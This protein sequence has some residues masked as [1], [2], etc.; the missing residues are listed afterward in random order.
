MTRKAKGHSPNKADEAEVQSW[1]QTLEPLQPFSPSPQFRD[2]VFA[3]MQQQLNSGRWGTRLAVWFS[4]MK[5]R[6]VM[7]GALAAGVILALSVAV[8]RGVTELEPH[9]LDHAPAVLGYQGNPNTLWPTYQFQQHLV[10]AAAPG[11]LVLDDTLFEMSHQAYGFASLPARTQFF[12]LGANYAQALVLL[13]NHDQ[14]RAV[15][16][17][18]DLV[19]GLRQV[20]AP[21]ELSSYLHT[22]QAMFQNQ[23]IDS[24]T[25]AQ[26]LASVES[27][28]TATYQA[29]TDGADGLTYFRFGAWVVNL[30]LAASV[31]AEAVLRQ[32]TRIEALQHTLAQHEAAPSVLETLAQL[33][34][35]VKRPTLT[36]S[37]MRQVQILAQSLK[38]MMRD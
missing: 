23:Q 16:H 1:F 33:H 3:D 29:A 9:R 35:L 36:D 22:L 2:K 12:R 19:E 31:N 7:S 10:R 4:S 26:V 37:E 38:R 20:Q 25:L 30:S 21:E 32:G 13:Q 17:M 15:Q 11:S 14:A 28:Y 34:S 24:T 8:W 27:L 5:I 6:P 18:D